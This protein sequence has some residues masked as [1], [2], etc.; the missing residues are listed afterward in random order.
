M[1]PDPVAFQVFGQNIYWYGILISAGMLFGIILAMRNAKIFD[2]DQDAIVDL[3]LLVI[4]LAIVGARLYYVV[5]EWGQYKGNLL[6]IFNIRKGGLAIYGGVIGGVIA[7]LIYAKW[8]KQ[9]FWNLADI[10]APSLILGQAIG[11]WGNYINQEAYGFAVRNPEW[12]WF[13]AAVFIEANQRWHLATFFYESFWNFIVFF[14]LMSYRKHRKKTG[15]VFLLYLI[16]YSVG[17]FFIEGLRTDSLYIG[18]IRVS[19]LFSAIL[20][21]GAIVMFVYRRKH[22]PAE[23]MEVAGMSDIESAETIKTVEVKEEIIDTIVDEEETI[24]TVVEDNIDESVV[25]VAEAFDEV[26]SYDNQD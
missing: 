12:Q 23:E 2:L 16:L 19:Q 10:C 3:T 9:D 24:K 21:V 13:P 14:I 8:K 25:E 5:F 1:N 22:S 17:R 7:G 4:P 26:E 6:D 20:F 18:N 11:R 15:E